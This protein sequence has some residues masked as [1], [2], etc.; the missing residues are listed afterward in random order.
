MGW[1]VVHVSN[2]NQLA[3]QLDNLKV[4]QGDLEVK[5][6]LNDIFALIIEDLSC[7]LTSRL[8]IE[9]SKNNVLVILCNQQYLPEATILPVSGHYGQYRQMMRQLSWYDNDKDLA[10]QAIIRQKV[11]NQATVMK[12]VNVEN[13]RVDKM[14]DLANNVEIGDY[15]NI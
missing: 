9:L 14:I 7:K 13:H 10:W 6:P 2:V 5:I 3:L 15:T 11:L 12:R 4:T 1:R 8:M